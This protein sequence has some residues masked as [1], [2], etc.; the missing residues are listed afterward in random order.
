MNPGTEERH[1]CLSGVC[2][3]VNKFVCPPNRPPPGDNVLSSVAVTVSV[4]VFGSKC[5]Q[6]TTSFLNTSGCRVETSFGVMFMYMRG[7]PHI[8][9]LV[10]DHSPWL[11][12]VV[13]DSSMHSLVF[14]S[15]STLNLVIITE[16]S[17]VSC[18]HCSGS[19]ATG[20]LL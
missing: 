16:H 7:F 17:H 5:C 4:S 20:M 2:C 10:V 12:C 15:S 8:H 3:D 18:E 9:V 13:S 1:G 14:T 11:P 6:H 19:V